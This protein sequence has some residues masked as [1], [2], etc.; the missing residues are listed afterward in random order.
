LKVAI[1]MSIAERRGGSETVLGHLLRVGPRHGVE[2]SVIF[3]ED[4]PMVQAFAD[5]GIQTDVVP[6]GRIRHVH[7]FARAV[8]AIRSLARRR[9]VD[10][11]LSWMTKA[12]L[13]GG[14]AAALARVPSVWYQHGVPGPHS[15]LDQ[16]AT[17]LPA[18]GVI[19]NSKAAAAAQAALRPARPVRVVYPGIDLAHFDPGA[20]PP[21]PAVRRALE[22][23]AEG[24]LVGFF[25]RLQHWKGA[26]VLIEAMPAVLAEFP[27]ARCVIVGGRHE[28]E[29][30]YADYLRRLTA[31]RGLEGVVLFAG[32]QHDV[33]RWLH[34]IDVVALPSDRE[35]FG[36]SVVEAMA[37]GKPVIAGDS[38]GPRETVT[39][40]V[41]GLLVPHDD[42]AA[43]A[44]AIVRCLRAPDFAARVGAAARVRAQDFSAERH[45][46]DLAQ[47]LGELAR[48]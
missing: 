34:A 37:M 42:P 21:R 15:R 31:E 36:I 30:G 45:A 26:H 10:L 13:Y 18:R 24:P 11:I 23:P 40:G 29:P 46:R 43:I 5:L 6:A 1:L 28:L 14:I 47:A 35:P 22:L 9:R 16:L 2:W 33:P 48:G 38:G 19:A 12:Q 8:M 32:F 4:G 44:E 27:A 17:F 20:L 39:S 41:D 7:R 3:L 25:G